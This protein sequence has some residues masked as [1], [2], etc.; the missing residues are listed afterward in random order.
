VAVFNLFW[1]ERRRGQPATLESSQ[2]LLRARLLELL[3]SHEDGLSLAVIGDTLGRV[4]GYPAALVA[5]AVDHARAFGWIDSSLADG[6]DV[7]LLALNPGGRFLLHTLLSQVDTLY[8]FGLDTRLPRLFVDK[9]LLAWH[10]NDRFERTGF[11]SAA[12]STAL[13]FVLYL[14]TVNQRETAGNAAYDEAVQ[15][16]VYQPFLFTPRHLRCVARS[17]RRMLAALEPDDLSR[18][19]NLRASFQQLLDKGAQAA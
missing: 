2:V 5:E 8:Y 10:V 18:L 13:C 16:G 14:C 4:F 19:M 11:R 6:E 15:S 7:I 9:G 12:L 1:R 17:A 3:A